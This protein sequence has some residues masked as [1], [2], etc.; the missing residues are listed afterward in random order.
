VLDLA[1]QVQE[2]AGS[3]ELKA[4]IERARPL[5]ERHLEHAQAIETALRDTA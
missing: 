2:A 4:M 5:I 3:P 1:E